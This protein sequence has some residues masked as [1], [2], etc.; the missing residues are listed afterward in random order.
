[1]KKEVADAAEHLSV[2]CDFNLAGCDADAME[3]VT[4][5]KARSLEKVE[6]CWQAD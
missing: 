4:E 3:P 5:T 6:R 2:Q 1:M